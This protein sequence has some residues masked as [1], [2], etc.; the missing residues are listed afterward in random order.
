MVIEDDGDTEVRILRQGDFELFNLENEE[1]SSSK[2]VLSIEGL[3][4]TSSC[5]SA[6]MYRLL[7]MILRLA[8]LIISSSPV[9]NCSGDTMRPISSPLAPKHGWVEDNDVMRLSNA[10]S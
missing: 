8:R 7:M 1:R 9:L 4:L 3:K 10:G 2:H 5:S 6:P